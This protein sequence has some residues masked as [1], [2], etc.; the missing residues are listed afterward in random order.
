MHLLAPI[1]D[2]RYNFSM[3]NLELVLDYQK[4]TST[5]GSNEVGN[6]FQCLFK[7]GWIDCNS[8]LDIITEFG[9]ETIKLVEE[10]QV[11]RILGVGFEI[12]SGTLAINLFISVNIKADKDLISV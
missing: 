7:S 5:L 10:R 11:R 8:W 9:S 6:I 3:E 1:S 4:F 12:W 2:E